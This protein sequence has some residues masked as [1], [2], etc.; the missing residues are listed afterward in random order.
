MANA[1]VINKP[2]ASP[3]ITVKVNQVYRINGLYY[4]VVL[5]QKNRAFLRTV[6][7][8]DANKS[9]G[10]MLYNINDLSFNIYDLYYVGEL[11]DDGIIFQNT[12]DFKHFIPN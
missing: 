6:D 4:V 7:L 1:F 12:I 9:E 3:E 5:I 2:L 11:T 8:E 10:Q